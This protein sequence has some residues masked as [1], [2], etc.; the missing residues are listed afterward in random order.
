MN[1]KNTLTTDQEGHAQ[2]HDALINNGYE[3]KFVTD[4]D[5]YEVTGYIRRTKN[6][7]LTVKVLN[8]QQQANVQMNKLCTPKPQQTRIQP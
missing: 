5:M 7:E 3:I 8:E 4:E 6:L 1:E 2:I